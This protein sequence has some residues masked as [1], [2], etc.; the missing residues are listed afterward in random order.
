MFYLVLGCEK[1]PFFSLIFPFCLTSCLTLARISFQSSSESLSSCLTGERTCRTL[2][3]VLPPLICCL[4]SLRFV[5]IKL[6]LTFL[7]TILLLHP[8]TTKTQCGRLYECA[9][10]RRRVINVGG[11]AEPLHLSSPSRSHNSL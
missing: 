4:V 7:L 10:E 11:R 6:S 5:S 3:S 8:T 2:V 1:L 9:Q